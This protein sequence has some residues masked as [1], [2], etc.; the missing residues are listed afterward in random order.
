MR[1]GCRAR[2][3]T[4][5][6]EAGSAPDG[7]DRDRGD[8]SEAQAERAGEGHKIYPYLL[9]GVQVNRV[10]QVWSTDITYIRMAQGFLYL[11]A[12]MDW[13]SWFRGVGHCR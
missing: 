11:V 3:T 13:F 10:N 5:K 12:V 4:V 1:P 6:P 2:A 8:L 7:S 9:E